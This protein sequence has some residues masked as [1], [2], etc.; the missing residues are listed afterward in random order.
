M[1]RILLV[2]DDPNLAE[3][4]SKALTKEGYEVATAP[5]GRLGNEEFAAGD[6]DLVIT[7]I[8]MPDQDGVELIDNILRLKPDTKILAISGG[9]RSVNFDYLSL[10]AKHGVVE[11]LE[12][13]FTLQNFFETL[14]RCLVVDANR[15]Y[16][17]E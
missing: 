15:G 14:R 7:D 11:T 2:E 3:L 12:K 4:L 6:F 1:P 13:P 5:D 17:S 10:A 8:I 9:A 16:N